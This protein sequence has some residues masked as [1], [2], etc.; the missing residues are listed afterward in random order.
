MPQSKLYLKDTE[1]NTQYNMAK[2]NEIIAKGKY[3]F[4]DND[5]QNFNLENLVIF[6]HKYKWYSYKIIIFKYGL[7]EC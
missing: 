2:K 6:L 1:L 7:I 5:Y 3:S 4:N